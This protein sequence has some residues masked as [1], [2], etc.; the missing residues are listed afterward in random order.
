MQLKKFTHLKSAITQFLADVALFYF[1]NVYAHIYIL[2]TQYRK[3]EVY[4][5][6]DGG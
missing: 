4:G 5:C 6:W 1:K 2:Y 3:N